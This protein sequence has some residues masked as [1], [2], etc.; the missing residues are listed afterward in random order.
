MSART[1]ALTIRWLFCIFFVLGY[2]PTGLAELATPENS[3]H[4]RDVALLQQP[5][6]T[7][8]YRSFPD[9]RRL[10][11]FK[12]DSEGQ[13][14]CNAGCTSAWPPLLVSEGM[15]KSHI[16]SWSVITRDDGHQQWAYKGKPVYLRYHDLPGDIAGV[17]QA[18]FLPLLP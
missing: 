14:N 18:G 4:P 5:D 13:S 17:E 7:M 3:Q 12:A 1:S 2:I 11:V 10:Y 8:G 6:G 9:G 16:G 15:N